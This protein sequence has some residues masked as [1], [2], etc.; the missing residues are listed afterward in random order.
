MRRI[1][2][3][4]L[5]VPTITGLVFLATRP[6]GAAESEGDRDILRVYAGYFKQTDNGELVNTKFQ[7]DNTVGYGVAA[8]NK[9]GKWVGLELAYAH[10]RP[11]LKGAGLRSSGRFDPGSVA[12]LVH[13]LHGRLLDLSFG[14]QAAYIWYKDQ[15]VEV[16][17]VRYTARIDNE[18]TWGAKAALDVNLLKWFSVGASAGYLDAKS[19]VHTSLGKVDLNPKPVIGTLGVAFK[20]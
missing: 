5:F 18:L 19:T 10:Y 17:G 1:S 6:L 9:F 3:I 2:R 14:P 15:T 11:D 13:P 7:Y 20:F 12:L 16:G 8:E 4:L